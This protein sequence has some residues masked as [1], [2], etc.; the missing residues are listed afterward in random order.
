MLGSNNYG[1]NSPEEITA[2]L[3]ALI[4][5]VRERQP[6]AKIKMVGILPRRAA[7]DWIVTVNDLIANMVSGEP[8]TVFINPGVKLLGKDGKIDESLFTDG[9]HPNEQGYA[10]IVDEI[11]R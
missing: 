8:G 11:V 6:S 4:R 7:E 10:R 9:L 5:A 1:L 3:Q 2:G